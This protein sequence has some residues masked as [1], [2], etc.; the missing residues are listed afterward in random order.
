MEGFSQA[1]DELSNPPSRDKLQL[2]GGSDVSKDETPVDG[3]LKEQTSHSGF[4]SVV[5]KLY[6]CQCGKS[7]THKSQRDRHMSMH[8]GLRPFGC[9]VCGKSFKW[10]ITWWAT[11]RSTRAL[12]PTSAAC[13]PNASCG[14]TAS[15]DI[16]P[17]VQRPIRPDGPP[18]LASAPA[19]N[20][21]ETSAWKHPLPE[22]QTSHCIGL[23]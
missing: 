11:W 9:S 2:E 5:Y 18:R 19:R 21:W 16:P 17:R 13:A 12:N 3:G 15:T 14:E 1:S 7:F 20:V 6:P 23:F 8:L 10:S 4:A 22:C